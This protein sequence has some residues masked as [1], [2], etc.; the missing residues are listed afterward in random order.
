MFRRAI[1]IQNTLFPHPLCSTTDE[2]LQAAEEKDA[3]AVSK[4]SLL[5]KVTLNIM[6]KQM[7][8]ASFSLV[9]SWHV[10]MTWKGNISFYSN[11]ERCGNFSKCKT[12]PVLTFICTEVINAVINAQDLFLL[13]S[14]PSPKE[15]CTKDL[16]N[17]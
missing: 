12:A 16:I 15:T 1:K 4:K 9:V 10:F 17:L 8:S 2:S 11:S 3:L 13:D 14:A 5:L 6:L 7:Q